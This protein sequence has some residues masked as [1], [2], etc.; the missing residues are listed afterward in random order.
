MPKP[1]LEEVSKDKMMDTIHWMVKNAPYRLAGSEDEFIASQY[2]TGKMKEYGLEAINEEL[3]T[4]NSEPMYSKVRITTPYEEEI[5]SLPCAHIKSTGQEGQQFDLVYVG[6]GSYDAYS[7]IDVT[8]K[9]VLVEVSYAPPVPEKARIAYEKGAAGIMCMNWGNDEGVICNRGLKAVWGNPTEET[10]NRMPD[11]VG[12][13][14]TRNDGLKLKELCIY[15]KQVRV[16]VIAIADRK[17]SIVHQPKGILRGNGKHDE[18]ILVSSHL[19]AWEPG[20]TCNAT[21]NATTLELCRVLAKHREKLDRDV[22]F[23]FWNGHEIAEAAGSTWFADN[24]WDILNKKCVGYINIDSTGI[25]DAKVFEIKASDELL[26]FAKENYKQNMAVPGIRTMSLKKIGDQSFM[27]IGIPS[28]AQRMSFSEEDMKRANGATLGWW[29]HTN[30]DG[31][32]K[33][34]PD[35]LVIDTKITLSLIFKLATAKILPYEFKDKFRDLRKK[36]DALAQKYGAHM[37]F[38]DLQNNLLEVEK[39]VVEIQGKKDHFTGETLQRYN[40]FV[41]NTSR[42]L[43]NVFHTYADK[44]QQDSYGYTK[45]S[46]DVPLFADLKCMDA[47]SKDSFEYGMLKTQLIKNKNRINDA[48]KLLIDMADLYMAAMD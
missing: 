20:V 8:G 27:G 40:Q 12:V 45:L 14:I 22:Y 23:V 28:I 35:T 38:A 21:G 9:M 47:L 1:M 31:L 5:A 30:A 17:W 39:K 26:E 18:F 29:N 42:L 19:D 15:G 10:V 16:K 3:F 43:T 6:D 37:D 36:V 44:Y 34:D 41:M 33:C 2:I 7:G 4:Y 32:D 25:R 48:L 46:A 11:I 13:G 24:Y